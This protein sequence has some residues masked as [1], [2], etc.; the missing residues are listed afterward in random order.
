[1]KSVYLINSK[2]R[3]TFRLQ[4]TKNLAP[5]APNIWAGPARLSYKKKGQIG[6]INL[7][8][9]PETKARLRVE[10]GHGRP[11]KPG[12]GLGILGPFPPLCTA[13]LGWAGP[14]RGPRLNSTYTDFQYPFQYRLEL[15]WQIAFEYD[16]RVSAEII[17]LPNC[18]ICNSDNFKAFKTY[19][20]PK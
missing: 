1:M 11:V 19:F 17:T 15:S 3:Q 7:L 12:P 20:L 2:K 6:P 18:Y 9:D 8:P 4:I 10:T 5:G 16:F 14:G 13:G